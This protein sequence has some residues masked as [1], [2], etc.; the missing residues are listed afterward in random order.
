MVTRASGLSTGLPI[1]DWVKALMK[2][3]QTQLDLLG[4][5]MT[6]AEWKQTDYQSIYTKVSDFGAVAFA[7]KLTA[8]LSP[9]KADSSN[10][11]VA[12]ATP[13]ASVLPLS[14][15]LTVSQLASNVYRASTEAIT[16]SGNE[17]DTLATQFGITADF[18]VVVNGKTISVSKDQ[19]LNTFVS[20]LNSAGAAVSSAYDATLDRFFIMTT[21]K[22]AWDG[23]SGSRVDFA[24]T[25]TAGMDF[26]TKNLKLDTSSFVAS[27]ESITPT[28]NLKTTLATQFG[29]S[30]TTTPPDTLFT[31]D[32]ATTTNGVTTSKTISVTPSTDNID[33]LIADI[34]ASGA[35]VE[36]SYDADLDRVFLQAKTGTTNIDLTGNAGNGAAFLNLMKLTDV[37]SHAIRGQDAIIDIDG[38]NDLHL[39]DN[40]FTMAGITYTLKGIGSTEVQAKSDID[41]AIETV[42]K[43]VEEYNNT[44]SA[45]KGKFDE[46]RPKQSTSTRNGFS[47]YMPLTDAQRAA[48]SDTQI[49]AWE[50]KAKTGMLSRS[51]ILSDIMTK[52]RSAITTPITGVSTY[53]SAAS[54]GIS[55]GTGYQSYQEGGKLYLDETKLRDAL[56]ADPSALEK[57]FGTSGSTSATQGI[58]VRLYEQM[59][60]AKDRLKSEAGLPGISY[61][62]SYLGNQISEYSNQI[63]QLQNKMSDEETNYYNRF[64]AMET[65]LSKLSSQSSWLAQQTGQSTSSSSG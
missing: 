21:A 41:K 39:V 64:S 30:G 31:F 11:D 58:A 61:G 13:S 52:M 4:Q 51:P 37:D 26:F 35:N 49:A 43:F 24:G 1:D 62:E 36:A 28:G 60:L 7:D 46:T 54:I 12:T 48:M 15:S 44:L 47:Y 23:S 56:T 3:R 6:V 19:S 25:S 17:K 14:H 18:S 42:T 5:K 33:H 34:N 29:L 22:G 50:A 2:P 53:N 27:S 40:T 16:P 55:T 10:T 45:I 63:Y 9:M 32:I 20:N 38:A 57:V 65:A 8:N 59:N